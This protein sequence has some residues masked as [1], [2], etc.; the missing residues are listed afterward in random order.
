MNRTH[1]TS[2]TSATS[3]PS[4]LT[5]LPGWLLGLCLAGSCLQGAQASTPTLPAAIPSAVPPI[6]PV[7]PVALGS[8]KA[9]VLPDLFIYRFYPSPQEASLP[10]GFPNVAFC[11]GNDGQGGPAKRIYFEVHNRSSAAA[12]LSQVRIRFVN[13]QSNQVHVVNVPIQALAGQ[14]HVAKKVT[15]PANCYSPGSNA[16]CNFTLTAD[17]DALIG[18]R[19]ENNNVQS[20]YCVGPTF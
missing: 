6:T 18:E 11:G 13:P 3:T 5:W 12:P 16:Q 15:I 4:R 7:P 20:S 10:A 14:T 19:F 1:I 2:T 17:P 9:N 8:F